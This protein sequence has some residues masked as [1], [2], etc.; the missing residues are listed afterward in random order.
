M[1]IQ[2][3]DHFTIVTGDLEASKR[4]YTEILGLAEGR[5]PAFKFPGAWL[6]SGD[7][8]MLHLIASDDERA[9]RGPIDHCAFR[10]TGYKEMIEKLDGAGLK[11]RE[12]DLLGMPIRQ[13][14]VHGPDGARIELVYDR[15]EVA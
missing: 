1:T 3:L 4:F 8:P 7:R 9:P 14:F 11:Y 10:M 15:A 6:Y 13:V 2:A 5:R 12:N